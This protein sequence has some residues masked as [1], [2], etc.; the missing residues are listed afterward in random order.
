MR[1]I[2]KEIIP[3]YSWEGL[4][5]KLKLQYLHHLMQTADS[6]VKTLKLRNIEGK[7]KRGWQRMS[8]FDSISDSMDMNLGKVWEIVRVRENWH[9]AVHGVAKRQTLLSH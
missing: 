2:L 4:M 7:R 9:V 3:E 8:W 5:L 1:S 6:L